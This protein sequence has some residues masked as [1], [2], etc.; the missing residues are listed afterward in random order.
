MSELPQD[1][2]TAVRDARRVEV[3]TGAGIS[4]D[5][6]LDTFR[7][8]TTGLWS[9]VDPQAMA[10][11]D[12]WARDPEPM[13]AWYLW[14]AAKARTADPNPG[15]TAIADWPNLAEGVDVH[16]TT[17]NIDDLHERAG[18]S[19]VSH[20]HGSLFAFR[21]TICGAPAAEPELPTEPVERLTPP[22]CSLCGNPVRP[23]VVWFGEAL[24]Q[25]D[26]AEAEQ[27]MQ[28]CDLVVIV[29][30]SGVVYPAAGLPQVAAARGVPI[31]EISA[32]DTDLTPLTTWSL[33]TTAAEGLPALVDLLDQ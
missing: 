6:G 10:S 24:P 20:L 13:W 31:V 2:A 4:A 5:S 32:A 8:A 22:S 30:T 28:N 21:C 23:G 11:I 9:H 16:V 18:S 29:G 3:F 15:H 33:R 26:F 1:L 7:D 14:R 17:Q 12:S 27:S 19:D 25:Q